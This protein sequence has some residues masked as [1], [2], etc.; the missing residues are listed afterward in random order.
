MPGSLSVA[1]RTELDLSTVKGDGAG[2][3]NPDQ[4]EVQMISQSNTELFWSAYSENQV[5][6]F[7]AAAAGRDWDNGGRT[8]CRAE[9]RVTPANRLS[10]GTSYGGYWVETF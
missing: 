4:P 1:L 5:T 2:L 8:H 7:I 10:P 6:G 3:L 9:I